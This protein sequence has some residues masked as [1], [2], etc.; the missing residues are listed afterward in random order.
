MRFI[1]HIAEKHKYGKNKMFYYISWYLATFAAPIQIGTDSAMFVWLP[2][3]LLGIAVIYKAI[4]LPDISP[5]NFIKETAAVFGTI[6]VVMIV[7]AATL[8][9]ITWIIT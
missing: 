8:H 2:P 9:I 6:L 3:L 7:I 4:K 1:W 5:L